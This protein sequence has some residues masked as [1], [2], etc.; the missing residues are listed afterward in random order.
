MTEYR[1]VATLDTEHLYNGKKYHYEVSNCWWGGGI[2]K[3]Q[4]YDKDKAEEYLKLAK[5]K[6]PKHD[7]MTQER[8]D[9]NSIHY[10]HTNIRIQTR[11]VTEWK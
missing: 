2:H 11:E 4:T 10:W 5:E 3:L 7:K 9:R 6:C 8:T 1:I